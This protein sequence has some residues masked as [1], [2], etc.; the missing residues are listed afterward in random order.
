MVLMFMFH[1][2]CKV[3]VSCHVSGWNL[4]AERHA[5]LS[6]HQLF[7][8]HEYCATSD[9]LIRGVEQLSNLKFNW[10]NAALAS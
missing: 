4:S 8:P 9:F 2:V 1:N 7:F 5:I 3:Q 6:H 10:F